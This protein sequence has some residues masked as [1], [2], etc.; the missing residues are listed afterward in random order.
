MELLKKE[1]NGMDPGASPGPVFDASV[2]ELTHAL[3][4]P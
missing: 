2:G 4:R 1:I 3:V